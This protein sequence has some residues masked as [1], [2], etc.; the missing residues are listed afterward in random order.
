MFIVSKIKYP[1]HFILLASELDMNCLFLLNLF[2]DNVTHEKNET[3]GNS[4]NVYRLNM[5]NSLLCVYIQT[6]LS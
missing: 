6:I 2:V 4:T 5:N 3:G 1:L